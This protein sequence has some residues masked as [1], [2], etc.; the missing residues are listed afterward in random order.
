VFSRVAGALASMII[1]GIVAGCMNFNF[2]RPPLPVCEDVVVQQGVARVK[3]GGDAEVHYPVPYQ[4][5]P[6][7]ELGDD[8]DHCEIVEQHEDH[9]RIH[10]S[11]AFKVEAKWKARGVKVASAPPVSAAPAT[12]AS[13]PPEAPPSNPKGHE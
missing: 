12:P 7:L 2:G 1:G 10:N 11:S 13:P 6:N 9:F 5:P 8:S 3:A 4:R